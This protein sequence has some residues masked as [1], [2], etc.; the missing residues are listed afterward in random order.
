[1]PAQ[2]APATDLEQAVPASSRAFLAEPSLSIDALFTGRGRRDLVTARDGIVLAF[3]GHQLRASADGGVS[4]GMPRLIGPV[5][6]GCAVVNERNGEVL[7]VQADKGR[8]WS[9]A[10]IKIS[11]N[12]FKHG[13]PDTVPL[14]VGAIQPGITLQFGRHAGR[15][16]M[17]GRIFGPTNANDGE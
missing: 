16:L 2:T 14:S 12:K 10:A 6:M 8:T 11:P 1:V 4:W 3:H 17:P 9:R 13:L 15:L 5:A 7:L